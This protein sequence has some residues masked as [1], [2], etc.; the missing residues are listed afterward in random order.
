MC[1]RDRD[2]GEPMVVEEILYQVAENHF[3]RR[4]TVIH[5]RAIRIQRDTPS[6][7]NQAEEDYDWIPFSDDPAENFRIAYN[8][9]N[10]PELWIPPRNK[11]NR[12][13]TPQTE[14]QIIDEGPRI[15]QANNIR[16]EPSQEPPDNHGNGGNREDDLTF[17]ERVWPQHVVRW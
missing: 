9:R 15:A 8:K 7:S 4:E 12:S 14:R 13:N 17:G 5:T 11:R 2:R 6:G 16:A 1:I 10:P 3:I